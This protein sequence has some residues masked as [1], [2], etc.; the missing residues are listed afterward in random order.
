MSQSGRHGCILV[1]VVSLH[2]SDV[3]DA[4]NAADAISSKCLELEIVIEKVLF[5]RAKARLNPQHDNALGS[6]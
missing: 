3:D 6:H 1:V 4:A 2:G 5:V